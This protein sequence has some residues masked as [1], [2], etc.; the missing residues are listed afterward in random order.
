MAQVLLDFTPELQ[1]RVNY[2]SSRNNKSPEIFMKNIIA[3]YLE[4]LEDYEEAAKIS[5]GIRAGE[6]KTHSWEEVR[7]RLGL[8]D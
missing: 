8:E 4:D 2:W 3:E 7:Q 5:M 6:I 1:E